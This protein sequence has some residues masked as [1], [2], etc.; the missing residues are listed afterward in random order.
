LRRPLFIYTKTDSPFFRAD[1]FKY[2]FVYGYF[3]SVNLTAMAGRY[4]E[5]GERGNV[6]EKLRIKNYGLLQATPSQ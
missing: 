5:Q 2:L 1:K 3:K 4:V 6:S